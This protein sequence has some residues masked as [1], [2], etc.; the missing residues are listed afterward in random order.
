MLGD[1][2]PLVVPVVV[3]EVEPEVDGDVLGLVEGLVVPVVLGEVEGEVL[4]EV[5]GVV[6]GVVLQKHGSAVIQVSKSTTSHH[7]SPDKK[8]ISEAS[9]STVAGLG[10]LDDCASWKI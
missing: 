9:W 2:V 3:G 10:K 5:L 6:D 1:V 4:G 7:H 8:Q